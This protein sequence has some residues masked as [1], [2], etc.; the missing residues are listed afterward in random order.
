MIKSWSPKWLWYD[1]LELEAYIISNTTNSLLVLDDEVLDKIISVETS[2]IIQ[3]LKF[4]W[5]WLFY[6]RDSIVPFPYD[7]MVLVTY[8][9][10]SINIGSALTSKILKLDLQVIHRST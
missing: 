6:F 7:K 2:N 1:Y 8:L 5:Y 9:S 4:E 3:V 10:P